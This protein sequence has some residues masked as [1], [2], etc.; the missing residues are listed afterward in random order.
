MKKTA[1]ILA[2]MAFAVAFT[3]CKK[4]PAA[5]EQTSA[6]EATETVAQDT[7]LPLAFV[8]LELLSEN[9]H[10]AQDQREVL[11]KK[12]NNYDATLKAK[13]SSFSKEYEDHQRKIQT[14]SYMSLDRAKQVES[15]LS[16]QYED[17]QALS[18]KY[19]QELQE[20]Q[21]TLIGELSDSLDNYL[22]E[23]NA[24]GKYQMIVNSTVVLNMVDGYDITNEVIEALNAR[25]D[26]SKAATK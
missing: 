25:Y 4:A 7:K 22:K 5:Q 1:F 19:S 3:S 16:K 12:G 13:E 17:L 8:D 9:Y 14:N 21:L 2:I 15:N 18:A 23:L 20:A 24:D 10:Y 26:A 6:N 11:L